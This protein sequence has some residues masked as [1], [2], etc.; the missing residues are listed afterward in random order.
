MTNSTILVHQLKDVHNLA[1]AI[2]YF[3]GG[4]DV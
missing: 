2:A 3:M 4:D 1:K